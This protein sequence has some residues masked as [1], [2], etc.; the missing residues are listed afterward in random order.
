MRLAVVRGWPS[1]GRPNSSLK[2]GSWS[3]RHSLT[4]DL[5]RHRSRAR[6][7]GASDPSRTT[8]RS[9]DSAR[10]RIDDLGDGVARLERRRR[11]HSRAVPP[12]LEGLARCEARTG[13]D[14]HPSDRSRDPLR[15]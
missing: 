8:R 15:A 3:V 1:A 10:L 7:P 14:H 12:R 9:A 2:D 5:R 6:S 13:W 11:L 4:A